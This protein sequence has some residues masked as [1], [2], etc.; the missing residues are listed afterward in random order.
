MICLITPTGSRQDQIDLCAYFMNR[1]TYKGEVV[2]IIVDDCLPRTTIFT[3]NKNWT[4]IKVYPQPFWEVGQNTQGR[5]IAAGIDTLLSLE[6]DIEGIFIIEDDDY[7]KP[8]YLERMMLRLK[9]FDIAG[10]K[11]TI[12]YNALFRRYVTNPNTAH[13]SLF[14][15]AFSVDAIPILKSCYS[16]R[17][18]DCEFWRKVSNKNL[19]NENNLA[20][21]IKG[22]PGRAGIGAGHKGQL[23]MKDDKD[24]SYLKSL[25][26]EDY[27]FYERYYRGGLH[28]QYRGLN[29]S[30][31]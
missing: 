19:F 15:T 24:L 25:I 22:L 21:G 9:G 20:I 13:S 26:N 16:H 18:I 14:Q 6:K 11:N 28:A 27:K 4:V 29:Q 31:F 3:D 23:N 5:N 30:R 7:Y 1:Q 12:Y 10:E 2:W 8:E 17:F